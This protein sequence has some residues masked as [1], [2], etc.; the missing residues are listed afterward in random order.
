MILAEGW[1]EAAEEIDEAE[2][3]GRRERFGLDALPQDVLVLTAGVDVQRDRLEIVILGHGKTDFFVL[4][5]H[6]IWGSPH[7]DHTWAELDDFLRGQ[8]AH[9]NG[10]TLRLDAA[11]IDAGDGETM[12]AVINFCRPR[13]SRCVVAIKG[14]SGA[15][16]SIKASETKGSRLFILG[17]D[18]LK[19]TLASHLS[20]GRTVRF[21][22]TLE[23]RF[24]EELTSERRIVRY[25]RGGSR[26]H[27]GADHWAAGRVL[28]LHGLRP[29]RAPAGG[30]RS[31]PTRGRSR[32]KG[33]SRKACSCDTVHLDERRLERR[34]VEADFGKLNIGR[35]YC[36]GFAYFYCGNYLSVS[37]VQETLACFT[38]FY[39]VFRRGRNLGPAGRNRFGRT[40][41]NVPHRAFRQVLGNVGA[42]ESSDLSVYGL[43]G[44]RAILLS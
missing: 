15:R 9:P 20:R 2:L 8:W 35:N 10:E 28:G 40:R 11:G 14:A 19:A 39:R 1:R 17:V 23:D 18:G 7:E 43:R 24:F 33:G 27:L 34:L 26:A 36:F 6:V 25:K 4:A 44:G 37:A 22:D 29:R 12:D 16:P 42:A 31:G 38:D 30:R 13:F 5:Q 41:A 3:A 21:S 32:D